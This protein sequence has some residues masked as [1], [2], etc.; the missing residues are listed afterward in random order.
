MKCIMMKCIILFALLG[1]F[2]TFRT[3]SSNNLDW[4]GFVIGVSAS[5]WRSFNMGYVKQT[6]ILS[7]ISHL[8]IIYNGYLNNNLNVMIRNMFY[9][10]TS[11]IGYIRWLK[12]K[13][14]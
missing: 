13:V 8:P 7:S 11:I 6:Y 4:G 5:V 1:Y 10:L 2:I 3:I 14:N 9:T 12:V